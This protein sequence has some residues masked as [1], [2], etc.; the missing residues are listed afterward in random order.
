MCFDTFG[1]AIGSESGLLNNATSAILKI[2]PNLKQ[3]L[4]N[5]PAKQKPKSSLHTEEYCKKPNTG[6]SVW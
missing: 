4:E 3:L 1:W 6:R 5:W 2:P